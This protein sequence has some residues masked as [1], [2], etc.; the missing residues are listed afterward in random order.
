MNAAA[1]LS[2]VYGFGLDLRFNRSPPVVFDKCRPGIARVVT[3]P[4]WRAPLR[5]AGQLR[6]EGPAGP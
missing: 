1:D 5:L 4:W 2:A 3:G 6:A